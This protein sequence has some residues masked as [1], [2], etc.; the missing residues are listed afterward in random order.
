MMI[1][2]VIDCKC[3]IFWWFILVV[4]F[5]VVSL[6]G[7]GEKV[8][9]DSENPVDGLFR[10]KPYSQSQKKKTMG[11]VKTVWLHIFT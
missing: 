3:E 4:F 9:K 8:M 5:G 11:C 2:E 7:G 10:S 6:V 1:F